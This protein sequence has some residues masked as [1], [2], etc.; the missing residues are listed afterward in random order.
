MQ[1]LIKLSKCGKLKETKLY[2]KNDDFSEK[3]VFIINYLRDKVIFYCIDNSG[4]L[5]Y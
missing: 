3:A 2:D 1:N 4:N 5:T